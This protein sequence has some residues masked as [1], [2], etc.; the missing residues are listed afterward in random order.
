MNFKYVFRKLKIFEADKKLK[1]FKKPKSLK[2]LKN[3]FISEC[4]SLPFTRGPDNGRLSD[5]ICIFESL[6]GFG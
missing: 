5:S 4:K 1:N 6:L 3:L 2:N